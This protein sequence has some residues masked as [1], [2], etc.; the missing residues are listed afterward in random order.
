MFKCV[1]DPV[2]CWYELGVA[3]KGKSLTVT[4]CP[5]KIQQFREDLLPDQPLLKGV[6]ARFQIPPFTPL[7]EGP[8]GF[9]KVLKPLESF[10][11][12]WQMWQIDLPKSPSLEQINWPGIYQVSVTLDAL[13]SV[14]FL[15]PKLLHSVLQL[16]ECQLYHAE[17][18]GRFGL[19]VG[20]SA[21]THEWIRQKAADHIPFITTCMRNA[22]S[23]LHGVGKK[24]AADKS[25][26]EENRCWLNESRS[27]IYFQTLGNA[28]D[29]GADGSHL[30]D[31]GENKGSMLNPHNVDSP[32]Q[33]LVL[34][35]G[36]AAM[37]QAARQDGF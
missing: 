28:C 3:R 17:E 21:H 18:E 26:L 19:M 20:L 12:T 8:W 27:G 5:E 2:P 35:V 13:F 14:L 29:L 16:L 15:E 25:M 6:D 36:V 33:A 7:T 9:G 23:H 30:P 1:L 24:K 10:R 34:L 31:P 11:P 4:T 32:S 22:Y 37:H